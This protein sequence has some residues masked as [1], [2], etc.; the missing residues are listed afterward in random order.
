M[1]WQQP[2]V[3]LIVAGAA[4][5]LAWLWRGRKR[6]A[7]GGCPSSCGGEGSGKAEPAVLVQLEVAPRHPAERDGPAAAPPR[8]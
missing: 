4:L 1:D 6:G 8:P 2:L 5:Y 3:Y 7:C